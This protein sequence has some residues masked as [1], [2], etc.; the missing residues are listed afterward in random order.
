[1]VKVVPGLTDD[2]TSTLPP[3]ARTSSLTIHH[4]RGRRRR[5]LLDGGPA[6]RAAGDA[7]RRVV[8]DALAHRG[9]RHLA[10]VAGEDEDLRPVIG[11]HEP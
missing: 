10:G 4:V 1:M 6:P 8:L 11:I 5:L 9:P 7:R 3:W 2:V